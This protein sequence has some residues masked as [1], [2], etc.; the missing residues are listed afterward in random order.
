MAQQNSTLLLSEWASQVTTR[1]GIGLYIRP[2]DPSDRE[3]VMTFLRAV[4]PPDL[5]F[6]FLNA[7]KPSDELAGIFTEVDH[8]CAEDLI[9]FDA[10]GSIVG[11]A[12]IAE[13]QSHGAAEVAVLVRSDLKGHGI[14]WE[15]LK[16]ACNY[17]RA[18]GF[19]RVECVESS[20][21]HKAITLEREQGFSSKV[22]PD[23]AE[24]TILEKRFG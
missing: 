9:A 12:M 1:D 10:N 4:D 24:L 21:N 11:T 2:A 22:H 23:S 3:S 15:L 20:S 13:G 8:R 17:A 14:G 7:V 6:R 18:R 16:Q 5:R 19:Q